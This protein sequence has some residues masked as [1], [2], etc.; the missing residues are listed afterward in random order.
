MLAFRC[1]VLTIYF[2]QIWYVKVNDTKI[3]GNKGDNQ[4]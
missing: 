1:N 3:E 4:I 2:D